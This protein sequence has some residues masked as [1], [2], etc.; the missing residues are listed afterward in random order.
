MAVAY[1]LDDVFAEHRPPS[2]H[3]ERPE[4]IEAVRDALKGAGLEQR[5]IRLPTRRA[6]DDEIGRVH[7]RGYLT[8]LEQTVPDA[9]GWLDSDTY[10]SPGSWPATLAAAGAAV[11]VTLGL[12]DGRFDRGLALVRPPGHH[13]EADRAMGF[14]L[15]NN[16][17]VAAA[18]ARAAGAARVAILD[19]DVHHGNGTQ[20]MFEADPSVMYLS[21]HQYPFYPGTGA[22]TETGIGAGRGTTVNVGLPAGCGDA[23][24]G[25]VFDRVMIPAIRQFAPEIILISAGFDAHLAD[26]LAAMKLT[27]DGYRGMARRMVALADEVAGGRLACV[28]EGGYDLGGLSTGVLEVLD[29][30]E[31]QKPTYDETDADAAI[32]PAAARAIEQTLAART[33]ALAH[34]GTPGDA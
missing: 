10:F 19:W 25:A 8:E 1:V 13:A 3:P 30:M 26:P 2:A 21:C 6:T 31:Q 14:C 17:A 7:T 20:H 11:D 27:R 18:S 12:L 28:L 32:M 15:V 34:A 29:A 22:A 33:Q 5:G 16:I 24:Y 4:R 23:E 9:S